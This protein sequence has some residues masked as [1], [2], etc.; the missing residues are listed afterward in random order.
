MIAVSQGW[1]D[2]QKK[3]VR[4]E[5]NIDIYFS[6]I[7]THIYKK[8]LIN[9]NYKTTGKVDNTE[10]FTQEITFE[11]SNENNYNIKLNELCTIKFGYLINGSWEWISIGGFEV[12]KIERKANGIT[13]KYK[14]GI[15]GWNSPLEGEYSWKHLDE[16]YSDGSHLYGSI[17][18]EKQMKASNILKVAFDFTISFVPYDYVLG[19]SLKPVSYSE[20]LQLLAIATGNTIWRDKSPNFYIN[21]QKIRKEILDVDYEINNFNSYK[22]VEFINDEHYKTLTINQYTDKIARD[23]DGKIINTGKSFVKDISGYPKQDI[24][25]F[26]EVYWGTGGGSATTNP[27]NIYLQGTKLRMITK[28]SSTSAGISCPNGFSLMDTTV[29]TYTYPVDSTAQEEST[30]S[31]DNPLITS[32]YMPLASE[33]LTYWLKEQTYME[34]DFRI[35]PRLELFDVVR[36]IDKENNTHY[37]IVEEI[38]IKYDGSFNGTAKVRKFKPDEY[39]IRFLNWDSTVLQSKNYYRG[40]TPT[41]T[42]TPVRDYTETDF[43]EFTGWDS[44]ITPAYENWDYT[45]QYKQYKR[46]RVVVYYETSGDVGGFAIY[47]DNNFD[48]YVKLFWSDIISEETVIRV[49][50][51][52]FTFYDNTDPSREDWEHWSIISQCIDNYNNGYNEYDLYLEYYTEEQDWIRNSP[53]EII[54]EANY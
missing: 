18:P 53:D 34:C 29:E 35:D 40:E 5:S 17:S 46:V 43:Y 26:D 15:I 31:V 8:E 48:I 1:K 19:Q 47:N 6:D 3:Q 22:F 20:L 9:F 11:V 44:A 51:N 24:T 23:G 21:I 36:V 25:T 13:T 37:G 39:L 45:A 27:Q 12:L 10:L 49:P 33:Y 30:F 42:L 32:E 4:S 50:A 54:L 14:L 52:S 7:Y 38:N 16:T 2:N 28:L 41:Y